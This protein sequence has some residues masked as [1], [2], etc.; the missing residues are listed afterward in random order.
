MK[1][2]TAIKERRVI[3][4]VDGE[5]DD[6]AA[7]KMVIARMNA[8]SPIGLQTEE[9]KL[10]HFDVADGDHH[11]KFDAEGQRITAKTKKTSAPLS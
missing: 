10:L 1:T 8:G 5:C 3:Y 6:A 9:E 11:V 7:L 2:I 4:T